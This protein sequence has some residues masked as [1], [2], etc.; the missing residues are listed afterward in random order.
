ML[1][2][3]FLSRKV[4]SLFIITVVSHDFLD[5]DP[6]LSLGLFSGTQTS[7][8]CEAWHSK[9]KAECYECLDC[10]H[11]HKSVQSLFTRVKDI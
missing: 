7:R 9:P 11:F 3:H 2:Q 1:C 5:F 6:F 4:L 10:K 8:H